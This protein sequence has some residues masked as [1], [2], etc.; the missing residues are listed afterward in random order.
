VN[1]NDKCELPVT[2]RKK[3][4]VKEKRAKGGEERGGR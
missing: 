3:R 2:R 4:R 1:E